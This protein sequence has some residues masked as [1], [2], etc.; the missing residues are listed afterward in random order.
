MENQD[1]DSIMDLD[2]LCE[3]LN[4]R[5]IFT[6]AAILPSQGA[7][8]VAKKRRSSTSSSSTS[9]AAPPAIYD[10]F[11]MDDAYHNL[12]DNTAFESMIS[13]V[14]QSPIRQAIAPPLTDLF[15]STPSLP[16]VAEVNVITPARKLPL[17]GYDPKPTFTTIQWA[18]LMR[19]PPNLDIA[20]RTPLYFAKSSRIENVGEWA[21]ALRE[22]PPRGSKR[23]TTRRPKSSDQHRPSEAPPLGDVHGPDGFPEDHISVAEAVDFDLDEL[24]A[25]DLGEDWRG[26]GDG[27]V[28]NGRTSIASSVDRPSRRESIASEYF[29]RRLSDVS[30]VSGWEEEDPK[31]LKEIII[32]ELTDHHGKKATTVV[33]FTQVCPERSHVSRHMAAKTFSQILIL[34]SQGDIKIKHHNFCNFVSNKNVLFSVV[35]VDGGSS[36]SSDY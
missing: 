30:M 1:F 29:N 22:G 10:D 19:E 6:Q 14:L 5:N 25:A 33:D 15:P 8:M 9:V 31:N 24:R 18:R 28:T 26:E 21:R 11:P 4:R 20:K 23:S 16:P 32:H 27:F 17:R 35:L 12:A 3:E 34:A 13:A 2:A 7:G 36:S